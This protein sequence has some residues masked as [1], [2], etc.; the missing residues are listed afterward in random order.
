MTNESRNDTRV[1]TNSTGKHPTLEGLL[2]KKSREVSLPAVQNNP[3][4]VFGK[5]RFESILSNAFRET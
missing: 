3:V 2:D 1:Q 4:F 5:H